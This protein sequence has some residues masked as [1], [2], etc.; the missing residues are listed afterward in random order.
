MPFAVSINVLFCSAKAQTLLLLI[1][2]NDWS[3]T[4]S[5]SVLP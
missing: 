3:G 5:Q 2:S 4:G 1:S